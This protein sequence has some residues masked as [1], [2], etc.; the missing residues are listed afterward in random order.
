MTHAIP[1]FSIV[2]PTTRPH[3]LRFSLA[4][5]LAQTM[6]NFEVIISHNVPLTAPDLDW[7]PHDPRIRYL[8]PPQQLPQYE[9]WDFVCQAARG[10]WMGLLGDD[11]ALVPQALEIAMATA[12]ANPDIKLMSWNWGSFVA[13]DWPEPHIRGIASLPA[14]TGRIQRTS[15]DDFLTRLFGMRAADQ[16]YMKKF[17]PSIMRGS[18]RR[19]LREA[20]V[21]RVGH[22]CMAWTPDYAAACHAMT[23][24][25]EMLSIDLPLVI[26]GTTTDSMAAIYSGRPEV[27]QNNF[28]ASGSPEYRFTKVQA[29]VH[30]RPLIAETIMLMR[31]RVPERLEKYQFDI[32]NFLEWHYA[33]LLERDAVVNTAVT[34]LWTVVGQLPAEQQAILLPRLKAVEARRPAPPPPV[35]TR[36]RIKELL[37]RNRL[38]RPLVIAQTARNGANLAWEKT[39]I[40]NI[41]DFAAFVGKIIAGNKG[42]R[43]R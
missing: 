36:Q 12:E 4:S 6:T 21:A 23:Y 38:L 27:Y 16:L 39:A 5:V 29:K 17:L 31:E 42:L 40:R 37:L 13:E 20:L 22:I 28:I 7:L 1:K 24:C 34:E 10:D 30:S 8:R 41:N 33:G 32:L 19:D 35:S 9:N 25:E 18:Y 26:L 43:V 14:F 15:C 11:D 2:I 3:L